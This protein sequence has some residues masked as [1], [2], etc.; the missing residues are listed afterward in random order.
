MEHK[1][2]NIYIRPITMDDSDLIVKWRANPRVFN[3]FIFDEPLTKA[4]HINW[5]N[6]KVKS[7]EVVQ[8]IILLENQP[9]GSAY[10]NHINKENSTAEYGIFIGEDSAIGRGIGSTVTQMIVNYGFNE[11]NLKTIY[12]RVFKD[13]DIAIKSYKNVGFEIIKNKE[14]VVKKQNEERVVCFMRKDRNE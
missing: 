13:N 12:L 11:M 3:N 5:M 4:V 14:E 8:F 9:I 6:T 10:L 7:G 2:L 1:K